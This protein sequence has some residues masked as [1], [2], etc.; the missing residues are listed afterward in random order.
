[1]FRDRGRSCSLLL[2]IP[3]VVWA[4]KDL[5]AWSIP[6]E[7]MKRAR[8][9]SFA[10]KTRICEELGAEPSGEFR[11]L[12][13]LVQPSKKEIIAWAVEATFLLRN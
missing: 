8:T 4:K 13:A 1:M 2:V 6:K 5:A 7:N 9:R 3:A 10:G 11:D 12:G